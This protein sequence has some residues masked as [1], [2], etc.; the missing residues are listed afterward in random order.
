MRAGFGR[1]KPNGFGCVISGQRLS[2][3]M[4]RTSLLFTLIS[5]RIRFFFI[6]RSTFYFVDFNW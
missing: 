6:C 2:A 1:M 5:I 4:G 3:W